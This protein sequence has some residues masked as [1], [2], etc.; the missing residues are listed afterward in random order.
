MRQLFI[1]LSALLL[2]GCGGSLAKP[3]TADIVLQRENN[4]SV[5]L[6]ITRNNEEASSADRCTFAEAR[7]WCALGVSEISFTVNPSMTLYRAYVRNDGATETLVTA[8]VKLDN[9]RGAK[10]TFRVPAHQT[11][12]AFE[13]GIETVKVKSGA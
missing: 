4:A 11:T 6:L 12:W 1:V 5:D 13:V 3:V 8:E 10:T 2:S 9:G 7:E